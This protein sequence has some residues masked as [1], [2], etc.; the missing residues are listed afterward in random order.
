MPRVKVAAVTALGTL[1]VALLLWLT[2]LRGPEGGAPPWSAHLAPINALLNLTTAVLLI[3]G[4]IAIKRRQKERHKAL[5][6]AA[7][8]TSLL[9]LVGYVLYHYFH[10]ES[11][12]MGQGIVRPVYFFVLIS[13]IVLSAVEVPLILLTHFFAW[14]RQFASHRRV[15]KWTFPVWL[16]VSSTGVIIFVML[17]TVG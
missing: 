5:M 16:Y 2:Y 17:K 4:F 1:V 8:A 9:F 13:H 3:L 7:T 6:I 11:R 15:A 10:G 12:F 14:T